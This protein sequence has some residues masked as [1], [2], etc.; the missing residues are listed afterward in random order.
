MQQV[1]R[2]L[3]HEGLEIKDSMKRVTLLTS[4]VE[5]STALTAVSRTVPN[6]PKRVMAVTCRVVVLTPSL[7]CHAP[8][9]E[10]I[11]LLPPRP[12]VA[13]AAEDG[14]CSDVRR[15][16]AGNLRRPADVYS[17]HWC[18]KAAAIGVALTSGLG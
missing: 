9:T 12:D 18:G 2:Q 3:I 10:P 11:G 13:G 5:S 14:D 4:R 8:T 16:A 17:A 1:T 15:D 7:N 6:F